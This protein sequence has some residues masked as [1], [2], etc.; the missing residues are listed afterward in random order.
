M[1]KKKG[2]RPS[3]V[4]YP[5]VQ[6]FRAMPQELREWREQAA[7]ASRP[8]GQWIRLTLNKECVP[9]STEDA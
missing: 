4:L 9:K 8:L 5:I 3:Q 6:T 2:S 1:S 7:A